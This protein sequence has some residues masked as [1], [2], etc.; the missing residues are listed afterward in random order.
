MDQQYRIVLTNRRVLEC[1]TIKPQ[2]DG[3]FVRLI[4]EMC[5]HFIPT[6]EIAIIQFKELVDPTQNINPYIRTDWEIE[7]AVKFWDKDE[8]DG[9]YLNNDDIQHL[10]DLINK[11]YVKK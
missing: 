4:N 9:V 8:N 3:F 6:N 10:V 7:T 1:D 5:Y 2:D 11:Y